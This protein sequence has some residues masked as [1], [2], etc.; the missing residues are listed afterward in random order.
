[1]LG[2]QA[3]KPLLGRGLGHETQKL[4]L[5]GRLPAFALGRAGS[6]GMF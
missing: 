6:S 2:L 4:L 5:K 3:L 1:M